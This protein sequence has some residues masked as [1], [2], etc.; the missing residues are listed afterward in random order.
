M[1]IENCDKYHTGAAIAVSLPGGA[2]GV[3]R[4]VGEARLLTVALLQPRQ[5]RLRANQLET[6]I[7]KIS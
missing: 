2:V 6:N 5:P 3:H 7:I 1:K 4:A